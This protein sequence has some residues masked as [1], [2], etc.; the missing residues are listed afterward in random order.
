MSDFILETQAVSYRYSCGTVALT[1]LNVRLAARRKIAL[2]GAN[3]AGK[4]T[5]LLCMNGIFRPQ[6]GRVLLDGK[7]QGYGRR[8][9]M[10]WRRRVGLVFQ[11]PDDQ[12]IAG[13]VEQDVALGPL[14]LGLGPDE[15]MARAEE[16]MRTLGIEDLRDRPTHALSHG[17]R[18]LV[19]IAGVLAMH[20]EAILLDE[21]TAGLDPVG[22]EQ[23]L[24]VLEAIHRAGATLVIS[25]QDMDLA[26]EWADEAVI[27]AEGTTRCHGPVSEIF[28]D[29]VLIR[30]A[31]LR[32][33]T[34][35]Q[36]V[37]H[38]RANGF[39]SDHDQ[40]IRSQREL[41]ERLAR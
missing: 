36:T 35:L 37:R 12:V 17:K 38:L 7:P 5:L 24:A 8:A 6:A 21:P 32:L 9:L 28:A 31:K 33:P 19:A 39:L 41:L 22:T 23:V 20:P 26:Y 25:T 10:E 13:T 30:E 16:T 4:T 34:L 3:G 14:N 18:K 40:P 27:L 2:L 29:E 11:D 1:N 15:A